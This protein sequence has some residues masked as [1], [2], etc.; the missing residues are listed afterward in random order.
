MNR[1]R[2]DAEC[3]RDAML[4]IGGRLDR[5]LGGPT[6]KKGTT[7]EITYRFDDRRRSVYTPIFRNNLLELFEVFDFGDPNLVTGR[8]NVSTVATQALYLMNSPFVREQARHAAQPVL[9]AADL[10]DGERVDHA[11]RLA[12][13]PAAVAARAGDCA[14]VPRLVRRRASG[15]L[16]TVVSG[17]VCVHRFPLC[18]LRIGR[19]RA[20]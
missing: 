14:D 16:G 18:E 9:A 10:D 3:L 12:A 15:R 13:G 19:N 20:I 2:L 5:T 6:I 7:S 11:Y 8:R 1:R 4:A 17:A